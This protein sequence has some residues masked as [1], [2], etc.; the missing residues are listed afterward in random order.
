MLGTTL[1]LTVNAVAKTLKRN[2]DSEPYTAEYFLADSA[3]LDYKT[4]IKHTVPKTRG[5]SKESHLVR[6]DADT[7]DSDGVTI[8]KQSV[9]VVC[10]CSLGRQ[11]DTNLN[12]MAQALFTYLSSTNLGYILARD[13]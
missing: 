11:D 10:E 8:R 7:F 5:L 6:F 4:T 9:W 13:S 2:N 1:V 12:Y 3:T